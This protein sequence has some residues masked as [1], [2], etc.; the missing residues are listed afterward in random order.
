MLEIS[1]VLSD[2]DQIVF[3]ADD[4]LKIS[5]ETSSSVATTANLSEHKVQ[6]LRFTLVLLF[7]AIAIPASA[8]TAATLQGAGQGCDSVSAYPATSKP[9]PA[10]ADYSQQAIDSTA[11]SRSDSFADADTDV[12]GSSAAAKMLFLKKICWLPFRRATYS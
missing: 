11:S 6:M 5:Q 7:L 4:L 3:L 12:A 2:F 8:Q 9:V 1:V 10:T